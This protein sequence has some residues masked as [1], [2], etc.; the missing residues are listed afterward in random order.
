[1]GERG[2]ETLLPRITVPV[3][4]STKQGDETNCMSIPVPKI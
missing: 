3:R 1:M 2:T 4:S